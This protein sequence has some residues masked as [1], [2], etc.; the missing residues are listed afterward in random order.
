MVI[1]ASWHYIVQCNSGNTHAVLIRLDLVEDGK[2]RAS[3]DGNGRQRLPF[4]HNADERKQRTYDTSQVTASDSKLKPSSAYLED[5]HTCST[6]TYRRLTRCHQREAAKPQLFQLQGELQYSEYTIQQ[7]TIRTRIHSLFWCSYA[8][9]LFFSVHSTFTGSRLEI[10]PTCTITAS[11]NPD[12]IKTLIF[13]IIQRIM[14]QD[15][16]VG[17]VA[18]ASP[19]VMAKATELFLQEMLT[20]IEREARAKSTK[21]VTMYHV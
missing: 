3:S 12:T 18:T 2:S 5:A 19:I 9:L 21:K 11:D 10:P 8:L 7:L 6:I 20:S 16:E 13:G 1:A 14:Q 17:K 15:D 4:C